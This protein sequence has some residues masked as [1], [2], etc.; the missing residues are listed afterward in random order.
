MAEDSSDRDSFL[1]RVQS[2]RRAIGLVNG[3]TVTSERLYGLSKAA[4]DRWV[5]LN[6]IE[7]TSPLA[8]KI[9]Q[10]SE[11]LALLATR[12]QVQITGEDLELKR[13]EVA[14]LLADLE[15]LASS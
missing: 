15:A 10:V 13:S 9:Y 7:P 12:S 1:W 8:E 3:A 2:S 4:I 5:S 14:R 11:A 6:G